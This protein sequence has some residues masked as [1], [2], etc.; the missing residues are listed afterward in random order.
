LISYRILLVNTIYRGRNIII[1]GIEFHPFFKNNNGGPQV[2]KPGVWLS[3][4]S[5]IPLP[6]ELSSSRCAPQ[7]H[8]LKYSG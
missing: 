3:I 1:Y 6:P 4:G 8:P 2:D 7:F 5:T